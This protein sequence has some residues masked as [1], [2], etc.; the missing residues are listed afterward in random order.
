VVARQASTAEHQIL[1][2]NV[3]GNVDVVANFL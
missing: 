1:V 2:L 3:D